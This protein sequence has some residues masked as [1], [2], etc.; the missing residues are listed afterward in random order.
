MLGL[1]PLLTDGVTEAGATA[2]PGDPG[3]AMPEPGAAAE[4]AEGPGGPQPPEPHVPLP[5]RGE[6]DVRPLD[7]YS[8]RLVVTRK[9]YDRGTLVR[10]SPSL[11]DLAEPATLRLSPTDFEKLG[12]AAGDHVRVTSSR[13]HMTLPVRPDPTVPHSYA[14][15]YANAP[16]ARANALIDGSGPVTDVRVERP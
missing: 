7:A 13:G 12:V 2:A 5:E 11:A 15:L 3:A 9:L 6:S 8:F 10:H 4:A 16:G 1:D 14:G